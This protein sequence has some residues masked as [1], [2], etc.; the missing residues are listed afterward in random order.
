MGHV[1]RME[2]APLEPDRLPDQDRLFRCRQVE[3]AETPLVVTI[4]RDL[5]ERQPLLDTAGASAGAESRPR[6]KS[7]SSSMAYPEKFLGSGQGCRPQ[8][9][10]TPLP[11][12]SDRQRMDAS[13]WQ[14]ICHQ[15]LKL[16]VIYVT[17]T[18]ITRGSKVAG[19]V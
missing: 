9:R 6:W 3:Q 2:L 10:R 17:L 1:A 14:E 8:G 5:A 4:L 13:G 19:A 18:L 7:D 12:H 16:A 15:G 11:Y